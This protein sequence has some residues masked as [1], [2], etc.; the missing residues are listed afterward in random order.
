[1]KLKKIIFIFIIVLL[2]AS[3]AFINEISFEKNKEEKILGSKDLK[4]DEISAVITNKSNKEFPESKIVGGII[5]HDIRMKKYIFHFFQGI[6]KQDFQRIILLA[7]NHKEKGFG[8]IFTSDY[9]WPTDYGLLKSDRQFINELNKIGI[10]NNYEV[11]AGEHAISD[12][13]PFIKMNFPKK[14]IVPLIF[15]FSTPEKELERL[16]RKIISLW[17][18]KTIIMAAVDF[19]HYLNV[20]KA[21]KRDE[22]TRKALLNYDYRTILSFGQEF[23]QYLDSPA[24]MALFLMLMKEKTEKAS[25]LGHA[26]SG[27]LSNSLKEP[28]T[29][30]FEIVYY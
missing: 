5:P 8:K 29:S 16:K 9:S 4:S 15:K 28:S 24:A 27:Y 21:N 19:S 26:N 10:K 20:T 25:I 7:P 11:M 17:D 23:N 13:V 18:E 2:L 14:R 1:M 12:L 3:P 30:Y 22:I 6:K